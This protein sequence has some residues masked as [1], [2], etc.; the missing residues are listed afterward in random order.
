LTY[1]GIAEWR[2]ITLTT[3]ADNIAGTTGNDTV[4]GVY[5]SSTG[6]NT[7]YTASDSIDG[8]AGTDTLRVTVQGAA[9]ISSVTLAAASVKNVE[10]ASIRNVNGHATA[11]K[12]VLTVDA[13]TFVGVTELVADRSTG[14]LKFNNVGK[15]DVSVVG[16]STATNGAVTIDVGS[17]IVTDAF[18]L[19]FK[20]GTK[21]TNSV[22]VADDEAEWTEVTINSTGAANATGTMN[23]SGTSSATTHTIKTLTI[24]A[25]TNLTIGTD[26]DDEMADIT[27]FDTAAGVTN[28]IKVNGAATSVKINDVAATIDVIDA[29]GLTAGGLTADLQA[30]TSTKLKV[31]GGAGNDAITTDDLALSAADGAFVDAAGGTADVLTV[32]GAAIANDTAGKAVAALYKNFEVLG[33][34]NGI[35]QDASIFTGSTIG[36]VR[37]AG[38]SA[39]TGFSNLSATQAANVTLTAA[40]AGNISIGVKD[41]TVVGNI[42]TVK[43][44]VDDLVA[45]NAK[46]T[47]A[48]DAT[49]LTLTGV[50]KLEITAIDNFTAAGLTG[51]ASVDTLTLKG[52]GNFDITTGAVHWAINSTIDAS[53]AT[54]TVV[55]DASAAQSATADKGLAIKGS[56]TNTNDIKDTA[57]ADVITGG[58]KVDTITFQGGKDALTLG[59]GADLF[60]F[61]SKVGTNNEL[62]FKFVAGDSVG[63]AGATTVAAAFAG[64]KADTLGETGAIKNDAT[65]AATAGQ[66]FTIDTDV[67]AV[68]VKTGTSIVFGTTAVDNAG[69]FFVLYGDDGAGDKTAYAFQDSNSNGKIDADDFMIK[70]VGAAD[71]T[72]NEFSVA[73]GNLVFTSVLDA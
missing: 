60:N 15:A 47:I 25:A 24:N 10:I 53:A 52:A 56:L 31:T 27:G 12:N 61:N 32:S 26:D 11:S 66:K 19:N 39:S 30:V 69:D 33:V 48:T 36:A 59:K 5:D 6:T 44:T 2:A 37:I 20:D 40:A 70:L 13:N 63:V 73:N 16:N 22:N 29:S 42:D 55:I 18:T 64:G 54:G 45:D 41:A 23:L 58:E 7:T 43:I 38:G 65:A 21:G 28:T 8:G 1:K 17:T 4:I 57:K 35:V 50:E 62:T 51:A 3:S 68:A 71:F 9:D 46:T 67:T 14:G 49:K 72:A 34:T